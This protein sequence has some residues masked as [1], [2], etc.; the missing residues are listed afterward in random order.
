MSYQKPIKKVVSTH[1]F[2]HVLLVLLIMGN[3]I[4][5]SFLSNMIIILLKNVNTAWNGKWQMHLWVVTHCSSE[6]ECRCLWDR[7]YNSSIFLFFSVA[8]ITNSYNYC[9]RNYPAIYYVYANKSLILE[10]LI[11][12]ENVSNIMTVRSFKKSSSLWGCLVQT[13]M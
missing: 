12:L 5:S 3:Y 2:F 10:I 11:E 4:H 7:A 13:S 9:Y 8:E 1:N 6:F